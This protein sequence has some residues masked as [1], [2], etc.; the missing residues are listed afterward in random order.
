MRGNCAAVKRAASIGV[1]VP[2]RIFDWVARRVESG[3]SAATLDRF[4]R[5]RHVKDLRAII[6]IALGA[7]LIAFVTGLALSLENELYKLYAAGEKVVGTGAQAPPAEHVRSALRGAPSASPQPQDSSWRDILAAAAWVTL[8]TLH[9]AFATL[10]TFLTFFAPILGAFG[11]LVAWAYQTGSSRLGVVDLFACE[12]STLCRV[13]TVL[14]AVTAMIKRLDT[15]THGAS[16]GAG[17]ESAPSRDFNSQEQYFPVFESNNKDLQSLEARVVINIT[18][19]YTYMKTV[20]DSMR[21]HAAAADV[22]YLLYLALE[23]GRKAVDDLVEFEPEQ[24]ERVIM[25]LISELKAYGFLREQYSRADDVHYAR[26]KLRECGYRQL[27]SRLTKVVRDGKH[28]PHPHQWEPA[29]LLL[30]EVRRR[31]TDALAA[32]AP[33]APIDACEASPIADRQFASA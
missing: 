24:A 11:A 6:V 10:A 26:L 4:F 13:T 16:K 9:V 15:P 2:L 17:A 29:A 14:D 1:A 28:G 30:P 27:I 23:S 20:R 19:F 21:G 25:V 32:T 12:I 5:S 22:I 7:V 33:T 3:N 8:A 18:A 31:H